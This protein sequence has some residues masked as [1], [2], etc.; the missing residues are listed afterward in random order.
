[1]KESGSKEEDVKVEQ[2]VQTSSVYPWFIGLLLLGIV[3]GIYYKK[4]YKAERITDIRSN[5]RF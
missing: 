1:L 3:G 2:V 4:F 5:R